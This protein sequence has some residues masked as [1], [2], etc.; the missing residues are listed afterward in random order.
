MKKIIGDY[1]RI[2]DDSKIFMYNIKGMEIHIVD[3]PK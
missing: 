2:T 1:A 3:M